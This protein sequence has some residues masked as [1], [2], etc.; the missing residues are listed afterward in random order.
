M[1][2]LV[3]YG[4]V[5]MIALMMALNY[6]LFVFPNSFAPA[7]LNG[8]FTMI[9]HVLGFK[10]SYTSIILN[11]PL[12]IIVYFTIS[13]PFA[14]RSL[15]YTLCFSGFLMLFDTIDLSPFVYSTTVSTLLGPAIAGLITGFG[16]YYMHRV[17]ACYG[18]TEFVAKLIHKKNPTFNL[19]SII[20]ALNVAVA[21]AS[22][23]VYD[24]KIEPVLL[25]IIYSYGSSSVRDNMNRKH[26]SAVRCEII[27]AH[28]QELGKEIIETLHHSAT[29]LTGKGLYTG[30]EKHVLVCVLNQSQITELTKLVGKYPGSFVTVSHVNTVLGNFK[31]LDS[32]SQPERQIYD[33]GKAAPKS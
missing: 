9:Q 24:Y 7:G 21:I 19:F 22:Y 17:G 25:C 8:I 18:G 12:A 10:L 30:E 14:M 5:V 29:Q 15:V 2:K 27:T 16:G 32:H 3:S 11:V 26:N 23:F 13:K 28:P 20:F 1:K 4:M 31:R 33:S 6:Q